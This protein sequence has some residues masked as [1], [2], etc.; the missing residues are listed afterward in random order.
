[1]KTPVSQIEKEHSYNLSDRIERRK[2][3]RKTS[4]KWTPQRRGRFPL[5]TSPRKSFFSWNIVV[6]QL[7]WTDRNVCI[8]QPRAF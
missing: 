1:M 5:E 8:E 4:S 7:Q 2:E 6:L 3:M